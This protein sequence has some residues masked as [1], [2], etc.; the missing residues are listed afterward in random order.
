MCENRK[1]SDPFGGGA[2]ARAEP[3]IGARGLEVTTAFRTNARSSASF[4][5][6]GQ[7]H[8]VGAPRIP[9]RNPQSSRCARASPPAAAAVALWC[10]SGPR[11]SAMCGSSGGPPVHPSRAKDVVASCATQRQRAYRK[12]VT[13]NKN[14]ARFLSGR[15]G[16]NPFGV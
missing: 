14:G 15:K 8:S 4:A 9:G 1:D 13:L 7:W 10:I 11:R 5:D 2:D 6:L 12:R 3:G 16:P